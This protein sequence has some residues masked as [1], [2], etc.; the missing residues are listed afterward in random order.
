MTAPARLQNK[1]AIVTGAASGIGRAIAIIFAKNGAS[2]VV[3]DIQET[4]RLAAAEGSDLT[5]V[6]EIG[7]LGGQAIFVRCDMSNASDV[8]ALVEE[9][10]TVFGRLDIMVN[11]AGT[12]EDLKPIWE[13]SPEHFEKI[14]SINLKGVFLG[15]KY[16]TAQ[17][18]QQ[19]PS[20][21]GDKGWIINMASVWGMA[22]MANYSTGYSPLSK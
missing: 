16:A 18:I 17:M 8:E 15:I 19:E 11:N 6:E 5:T 22:G 9:A 21:S 2:V 12:G 14:I 10:V 20:P 13:Y 7:Q 4:S 3:S 1:V